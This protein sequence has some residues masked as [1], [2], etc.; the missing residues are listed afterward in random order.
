M[1]VNGTTGEGI[2]MTS[3]E[4][5]RS[6]HEWIRV[7][8]ANNLLC[9]VQI[10]GTNMHEIFE[11]A[12][13]AESAG[14]DAVLCLPDLF[15][16]PATEEALVYYLKQIAERCPSRP[17]FYYHYPRM[18]GANCECVH[19]NTQRICNVIKFVLHQCICQGS[20]IWPRRRFR[21]SVASNTPTAIWRKVWHV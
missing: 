13:H 6:A 21:H 7:C 8:K 20:V 17:L 9:M 4:R 10:G 16:K 12:A 1:L 15:F 14:A 3:N 2:T 18:T 5:Q 11:L 19:F